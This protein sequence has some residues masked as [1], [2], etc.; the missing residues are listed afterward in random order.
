MTSSRIAITGVIVAAMVA[1]ATWVVLNRRGETGFEIGDSVAAD[2]E[3]VA[4]ETFDSFVA[5]APAAAGCVGN[6][7]LEAA[8]ELEDP[9]KYDQE[10][11][12]IYL[13]VPATAS[14]LEASLIHELAHHIELAC[15]THA[16]MRAA[17][18]EAQ[19]HAPETP[20]F[21]GGPWELRPSEQFAEATVEVVLGERRRNQLALQLTPGAVQTVA[22]WLQAEA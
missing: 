16:G 19:G 8:W 1:G 11:G 14:S 3:A 18:L 17:F 12:I 13:R 10:T 9:A 5:A 6:P 15:P 4:V 20:W 2:L 21:G 22:Q 7:R